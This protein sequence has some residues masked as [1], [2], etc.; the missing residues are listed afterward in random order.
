MPP[1]PLLSFVIVTSNDTS[2]AER[3]SSFHAVHIIMNFYPVTTS[4][5]KREPPP[6]MTILC[7]ETSIHRFSFGSWERTMDT[8]NDRCNRI[9]VAVDTISEHKHC[10]MVPGKRDIRNENFALLILTIT[11]VKT[12]PRPALYWNHIV[13]ETGFS[14]SETI[15]IYWAPLSN[16]LSKVETLNSPKHVFGKRPNMNR[17][18]NCDSYTAFCSSL[19]QI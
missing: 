4:L 2:S 10:L 18:Q 3:M 11:V 7:S 1:R 15:S 16:L 13:S 17:V 6:F 8:G 5:P 19:F 14:E 12:I 9:A